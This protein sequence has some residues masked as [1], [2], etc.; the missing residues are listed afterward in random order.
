MAPPPSFQWSKPA[1][2][3]GQST[4]GG[5]M[6]NGSTPQQQLQQQQQ[7]QLQQLQQANQAQLQQQLQLAQSTNNFAS[8]Q[9]VLGLGGVGGGAL[10][11]SFT[12]SV[13]DQLQKIKNAWD[14]SS[15]ECAFQFYFYN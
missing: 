6:F 13:M 11:S 14:P 1:D 9:S 8:N 4:L 12:P 3:L 15:P 7:L 10:S 2:Q 5:S